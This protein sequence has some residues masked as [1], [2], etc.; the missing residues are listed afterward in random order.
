VGSSATLNTAGLFQGNILAHGSIS[1]SQ[2]GAAFN[3]RALASTAA[4]TLLDNAV[5]VP[6]P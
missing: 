4:V 3:G 5:T 6:G 2:A 1:F